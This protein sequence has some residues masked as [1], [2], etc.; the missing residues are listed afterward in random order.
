MCTQP[1]LE[2]TCS[3]P[4][5]P[6]SAPEN[7]IKVHCPGQFTC[8]R[9]SVKKGETFSVMLYQ[10]AGTPFSWRLAVVPAILSTGPPVFQSISKLPHM[11]GG[12]ETITWHFTSLLS[13]TA[14]LEFF[15]K[16]F[17]PDARVERMCV[18]F[19]EVDE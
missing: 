14:K 17:N 13:G 12:P 10:N 18:V 2:M 6:T 8:R 11:C 5:S 3:S 15:Y 7:E 19:V 4:A 9:L 1:V 16:H